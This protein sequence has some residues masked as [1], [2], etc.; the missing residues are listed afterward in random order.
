MFQDVT[1]RRRLRAWI[2]LKLPDRWVLS[3]RFSLHRA[4]DGDLALDFS[5]VLAIS[6]FDVQLP[7]LPDSLSRRCWTANKCSVLDSD[8]VRVRYNYLG[9]DWYGDVPQDSLVYDPL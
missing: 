4:D 8:Q 7:T 5:P 9:P 3:H 2:E 1:D 6:D